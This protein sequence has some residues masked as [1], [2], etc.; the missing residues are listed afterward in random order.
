VNLGA[1]PTGK[2]YRKNC[3][4]VIDARKFFIKYRNL[5]SLFS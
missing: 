4:S 3:Q 2:D 1:V 5:L